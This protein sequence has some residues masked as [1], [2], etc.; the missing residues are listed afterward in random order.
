MKND[1]RKLSIKILINFEDTKRHLNVIQNNFFQ[2]DNYSNL[3]KS[4]CKVLT[5]EIVRFKGRIDYLIEE[6]SGKN[7]KYFNKNLISILRIA[8][9][10]ILFDPNIPDYASVSTAV[11]LTKFKLNRKASGFTNAVLRKL[12]RLKE[13]KKNWDEKFKINQKWNSMPIWIQ[14]RFD[15]QYDP[16]VQKLLLNSF[17]KPSETYIRNDSNTST[18]QLKNK[19]KQCDIKSEIYNQSFLKIKNGSKNILRDRLFQSGQIS[20]QDPAS[21]GIIECL[22]IQK[23]DIILDVCAAPGTKSLAMSHLVGKNGKII[24]SDINNRRVRMGKNDLKR[25]K[26]KNIFWSVK[27]ASKDTFPLV[28][29]ILIDAPCS[30]LGVLRRKPDIRW[31]RKESDIDFFT[32]LQLQILCH[33]SNFLNPGGLIVYGTCSIDKEENI[34]VVQRFLKNNTKFKLVE[35]PNTINKKLINEN[36]YFSTLN[37]IDKLDGMFAAR[38]KKND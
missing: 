32:N 26:R 29:K 20:I 12:I 8:F 21:Y 38:L 18:K 14:N 17:N 15:N 25:H 23:G 11:D 19:L 36:L 13:G 9:Y 35:M 30:G 5:N 16:A 31:R 1:A 10:E 4:R 34:G 24:S 7:N 27:D 37:V 3:I 6:V 28:D 33:M 2:D 22:D